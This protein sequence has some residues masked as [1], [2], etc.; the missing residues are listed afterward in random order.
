MRI[1]A[2]IQ[3]GVPVMGAG[4]VFIRGGMSA[5]GTGCGLTMAGTGTIVGPVCKGYGQ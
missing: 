5:V 3:A 1:F 2:R 4:L